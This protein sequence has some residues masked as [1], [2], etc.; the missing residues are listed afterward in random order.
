MVKN[1]G[2]EPNNLTDS[3][4]AEYVN[5]NCNIDYDNLYTQ[6]V[7]DIINVYIDYIEEEYN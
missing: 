7:L 5:N 3:E 4:V 2:I 1:Y 6:T